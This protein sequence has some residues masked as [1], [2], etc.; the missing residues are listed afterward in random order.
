M[1]RRLYDDRA[2]ALP[3]QEEGPPVRR[4]P[5]DERAGPVLDRGREGGPEGRPGDPHGPAGHDRR[6]RT[7]RTTRTRRP[8]YFVLKDKP[9]LSGDDI[10]NPEQNFDQNNQPNVTFDFT[11][12]GR[13]AFQNITREIAQRGQESLGQPYSFAIVLDHK[14]V[15]RPVIDY[16]ENPD[17]IDG[18]TG[19]QIS[20]GFTTQQAQDLASS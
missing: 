20:G 13:V 4:R 11:D 15:S 9:E 10:T 17:G 2:A 16:Q 7:S 8:R 5:G 6:P 14:I 3:V 12:Q 18:R 19:A 1:Q